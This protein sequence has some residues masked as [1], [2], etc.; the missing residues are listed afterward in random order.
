MKTYSNPGQVTFEGPILQSTDVP[1]SSAFIDYPFS[2]ETHFGT[3]GRVPV[4]ATFDGVPYS[5]SLVK[6]GP[7]S[8]CILILKEIREQLGKGRG[9]IVSVTVELDETPRTVEVP[10]DLASAISGD[11]SANALWEGLAYSHRKE[12]VA[13]VEGAKQLTTRNARIA[14]TV[15]MLRNGVKQAR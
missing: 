5:G 7:G 15:E 12:Y 4:K 10:D 8:H 3:K 1:N 13:W 6:M 14:R 9:D 2:V 11:S